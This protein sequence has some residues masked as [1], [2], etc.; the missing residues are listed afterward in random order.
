MGGGPPTAMRRRVTV[1]LGGAL[2]GRLPAM[3]ARVD[4]RVLAVLAATLVATAAAVVVGVGYGDFPIPPGDV[5]A[6]LVGRGTPEQELIVLELRLPRVLAALLAGAAFGL[7]GA[8]FQSLARNA[9][10]APDVIGINAGAALVAVGIIVLGLPLGL[11]ATG[12]FAGAVGAA[13][14]LYLLSYRGGLSA[15]RLVLVGIALTAAF[16]AGISY[17]LTRGDIFEVQ[18]ATVWL[19][20]SVSLS[21]WGDVR[22]LGLALLVLAP[23]AV[24]LG[25]R[26][27]ALRLGDDL[28]RGVGV[29]V[30][31]TRLS[32][33]LVAVTLAA[34][35]VSVAGPVAFVAFI[36]PHIA[37]RLAGTSGAAALPV[38]IAVGA[39]L[40]LGSDL[41][42]Q[43]AFAPTGLPVG[44]VTALLG[45]PYFLYLL[46]RANRLGQAV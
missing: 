2:G 3:S 30:E 31:R 35:G 6:T 46:Q 42:A 21:D 5:L 20:G 23:V 15:Y 10:V 8:V 9:L 16:D 39:L 33:V 25:R 34:L 13:I 27:D 45:A 29:P 37:R 1:R 44:I 36:A 41:V 17:L 4:L 28:A 22:T 43:H 26:L 38:A 12:A 7:S 18:R 11:V 14:L 24:A 40:V 32:L 19:I